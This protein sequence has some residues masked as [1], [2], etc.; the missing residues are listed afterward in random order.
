MPSGTNSEA[1]RP[2]MEEETCPVQVSLVAVAV[3]VAVLEDWGLLGG[4]GGGAHAG[5]PINGAA[6]GLPVA[7]GGTLPGGAVG[8]LL[9]AGGLLGVLGGGGLLGVLGEGGLLST[10]QGLT[11]LRIVELTLPKVSVRLLPGVGLRLDLYTRVALNGKSLLGLL[12]I[13]VEVNITSD[14]RLTMD[15][16]GY[17]RLVLEN[18]DT[19]LDGIKI[20]VLRG[21]LP[22]VDNLLA[23]VLNRLLP[24]LLC[25][26]VEVALGLV[27]DQLGLVN[28]LVP[29]GVLG[30]LQYAVSSLPLVT[31]QLLEV[32]LNT[33]VQ[34]VG[35]GLV[36][37]PLGKAEDVSMPPRVPMP[38]MPQMAQTASSQLGLSINFLES[39]ISLLQKEGAF[40]IDISDGLFPELPPLRTA[41][42]GA[43]VPAVRQRFPE[44]LPL[45]LKVA[46]SETP[47]VTLKRDKGL[48]QLTATVE[49]LVSQPDGAHQ[50]LC[51]LNVDA[52]LL[53]QFSVENNK[54]KIS[55]RLDKADLSLASSSI[56]NF[57]VSLWKPLVGK[58][59]DV[60]FLPAINSVLGAGIPLP[61]LLN[62]DLS[63]ADIEVIEDLIVLS[64]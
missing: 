58:I 6:G 60:A 39:L 13:A 29:L 44:S 61:R 18:C 32:D 31:G 7:A 38:P 17:P 62:A 28:S 5:G 40:T 10:V 52:A 33:I 47:R 64:A 41:T 43:L 16:T 37:Y 57:D 9:G 51:V 56:G 19:L 3:A 49:V 2:A 26:V 1:H 11:G 48:I 45:L 14:V 53:A 30:S 8:G 27:N 24:E 23:R 50:S 35:G 22:I 59:F 15:G 34:G 54:L 42:L 25:P 21:L 36:D 12:D 63:N 20:R 55:V 4:G 46:I